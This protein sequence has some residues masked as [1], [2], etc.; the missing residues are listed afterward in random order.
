MDRVCRTEQFL[1]AWPGSVGKGG[2]GMIGRWSSI[3]SASRQ[4]RFTADVVVIWHPAEIG[5]PGALYRV[6]S[7][8]N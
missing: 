1:A 2:V 4:P 7:E 8:A 5:E 6:S 3:A